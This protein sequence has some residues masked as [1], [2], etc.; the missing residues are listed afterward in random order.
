[1]KRSYQQKDGWCGPASLQYALGKLGKKISQKKLA[2][3]VKATIA[4]GTAPKDI[5]KAVKKMG[6]KVKTHQG[7]SPSKTL[8]SMNKTVKKGGMAMVDYLAGKDI[9]ND[10]HYS[11]LEKAT[12]KKVSLWDP[13][14][15][16]KRT[17]PT[18]KF[19]KNWKD[20]TT[21]GRIFTKW[22]IEIKKKQDTNKKHKK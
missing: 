6:F 18:K 9:N 7:K 8:A 16:K 10:G 5:K 12:K 1:M 11:V 15:G 2:R 22:G 14:P 13:S 3:K 17:I 4:G 20:T 19:I 21:G